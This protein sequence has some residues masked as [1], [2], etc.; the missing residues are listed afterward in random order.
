MLGAY[1]RARTSRTQMLTTLR[2][3]LAFN[4]E[5]AAA[6][7]R[8]LEAQLQREKVT[9][10][11]L[12]ELSLKKDGGG[13][14]AAEI[15]EVEARWAAKLERSLARERRGVFRYALAIRSG[16][17]QS[18]P[19][20]ARAEEAEP[21]PPREDS[22]PLHVALRGEDL[23]RSRSTRSISILLT[24]LCSEVGEH[25]ML[26]LLTYSGGHCHQTEPKARAGGHRPQTVPKPVQ[27]LRVCRQYA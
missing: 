21:Q 16:T 25:R 23:S 7:E 27:Y 22:S 11:Q 10:R 18:D 20:A 8:E 15:A 12:G 17:G 1:L 14:T 19:S 13:G 3:Q 2:A 5:R 6:L 4:K 9:Q 26:T 24:K